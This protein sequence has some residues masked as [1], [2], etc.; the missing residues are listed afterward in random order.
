MLKHETRVEHY[1]LRQ[2]PGFCHA[3]RPENFKISGQKMGFCGKAVSVFCS[4]TGSVC[5][6]HVLNCFSWS[7]AMSYEWNMGTKKV[8]ESVVLFL[9]D[10]YKVLYKFSTEI[11]LVTYGLF[12]HFLQKHN[13]VVVFLSKEEMLVSC[14]AS[15]SLCP[16]FFLL[17]SFFSDISCV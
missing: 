15:F 1:F 6:L 3:K 2:K 13:E 10:T 7:K 17:P 5:T 12:K 8:A 16:S 11:I 14:K 4:N 9:C